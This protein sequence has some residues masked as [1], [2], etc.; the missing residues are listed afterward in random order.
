MSAEASLARGDQPAADPASA[1]DRFSAANRRRLSGPAIRTFVNIADLW[2]LTE[3]ER[4]L[5]LGLPSRSAYYGWVRAGRAGADLTLPL[6]ALLR[7]SILLGI[8]RALGAL[9]QTPREAVDW[10]RCPH[11]SAVF[12]GRAPIDLITDGTQDGLLA[13]RGFL[14]A[15]QTGFYMEPNAADAD[16]SPYRDEDIV[17]A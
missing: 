17:I 11:D 2:Q 16:F 4:L 6:D 12:A 13:V 15:A 10:L 1:A 8:H 5:S 7:I 14:G 3:Q 9:H